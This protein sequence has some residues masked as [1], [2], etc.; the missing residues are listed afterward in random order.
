MRMRRLIVLACAAAVSALTVAA[1]SQGQAAAAPSNTSLPS[2]SGSAR[3]GSLLSA[4][5]GSWTGSPTSYAYQ[6]ERC[7][8]QG[9][10]CADIGGATSDHYTAQTAD[11]GHRLRVQVTATNSSGSGVA[12]S[13]PTGVVQPTGTAPKNTA[14]PTISG[15][16][17][18][19][20]TLTVSPGS[21][22]G[23]PAPSFS[24]QWER[25]VGTGGGC[26]AISGATS[27]TYVA[28]SADV[29]HT[30]LVQVTAK[31][32]TGSS[33]ANTAETGLIAPSKSAQGGAAI[34][35]SQVSLPNQLIIDGV[36]FSPSP[37]TTRGIITARFH[38]SDT[39]GFSIAGAQVFVLGLPY[40]WVYGSPEQ[41]TDSTGWAT[42]QIRPT[43]NMPLR[44]GDLVMFVR[45]R[46]P[47]DSLLAGVSA[48]R[49][50]Q[51]PLG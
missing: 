1:A 31:N 28:T 3:D 40:G 2:I 30:L 35:V 49:L 19:G 25:C 17:Q 32:A 51:E 10:S 36:K 48:R 42:I 21:W 33:T 29:A 6:W 41:P 7:D 50:V 47:G 22:S 4:S 18:D 13:R 12:V 24:Y 34:Q 27:T 43:R 44:R 45:A 37:A 23:T 5:H 20:A 39:R 9:G 11:V 16:Q 46:K 38:V 8:A 26:A 14:P 15:T